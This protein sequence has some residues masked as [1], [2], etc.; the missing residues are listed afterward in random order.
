MPGLVCQ[1]IKRA[2]R[3]SLMK[4]DRSGRN[5]IGS[6]DHNSRGCFDRCEAGF[7]ES[8]H[9][10]PGRQQKRRFESGVAIAV[11]HPRPRLTKNSTIL[12]QGRQMVRKIGE[13]SRAAGQILVGRRTF[14]SR[15]LGD[16][17]E[18]RCCRAAAEG[19]AGDKDPIH[20]DA[21]GEVAARHVVEQDGEIARTFPP[22]QETLGA[23]GFAGG[24]AVMVHG[25]GNETATGEIACQPLQVQGRSAGAVRKQN[26]GIAAVSGIDWRVPCGWTDRKPSPRSRTG[27]QLL[28]GGVVRCRIPCQPAQRARFAAV[29]VRPRGVFQSALSESNRHRISRFHGARRQAADHFLRHR[30]RRGVEQPQCGGG[31]RKRAY[32]LDF[33][34]VLPDQLGFLASWKKH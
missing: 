27:E 28:F 30:R 13:F 5:E 4:P 15:G 23:V 7:V 20:I 1:R 25:D 34:V 22:A 11:R 31:A 33:H 29:P 17:S 14:K 6:A 10:P 18:Q 32:S 16:G 21:L 3:Q 2:R 19:I 24:I 12:E 9:R 26:D 8:P